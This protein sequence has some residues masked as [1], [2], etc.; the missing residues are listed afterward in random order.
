MKEVWKPIPLVGLDDQKTLRALRLNSLGSLFFFVFTVL[1]RRRLTGSLHTKLCAM[2]EREHLKDV[3]EWPRDHFKS[4]C[5]PEGLSMWRVLPVSQQ[6]IDEIYELGYSDEYVR[7]IC[8]MH[9]PDL[10]NLLISENITNAAKLGRRIRYHFDSNDIY[11]SVFPETLPDTSCTWTDYSL[12]IK[13]PR[14]GVGVGGAHGEGTFDFLGV[15]SAV[16]SRHYNGLLIQDDL[17]GRKAVESQSI[18]DKTIE[19]HQEIVGIYDKDDANHE[20]DE[21]VIGNRWSYYDLNSHIREHEPWFRVTSHSAL[22]GCCAAHPVNQPIFP[23]EF[24]FDK[25]L[26]IRKRL[27][28]HKFSCFFLNNP[29][30]PEDADFKVEWLNYYTLAENLSGE[31]VIRREVTNGEVQKDLRVKFLSKAMTVDPNHSG[32]A[33]A[34]RCRHAIVVLA[35]SEDGDFFLLEEWAAAASYGAFYDKIFEIA[36]KWKI[37]HVG[38]ETVAAQKYVKHHIESLNFQKSWPLRV[39]E[40]KG[41]VEAPDGTLS[42]KKAWR[43]RNV[44][45]PLAEFGHLWIQRRHQNFINE[46]QTFPNGKYKDVLDAFAYAPQ[47]VRKPM[48]MATHMAFMSRQQERMALVGKPYSAGARR[49]NA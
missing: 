8:L 12:H 15:G 40:L 38:V 20:N 29:S 35:E 30:A 31:M 45:A 41:E 37:R 2:L 43:I 1:K 34:G 32:N 3:I 47:L 9:N 16:Q 49:F 7:W 28:S 25:L 4:T 26:Q 36:E 5:G 11:R 18:M 14:G 6:D 39:D 46:F 27:G 17:V 42:H 24:S 48:D 33:G 19:Y 21:L 22:G 23:E 13:R 44:I 10:R